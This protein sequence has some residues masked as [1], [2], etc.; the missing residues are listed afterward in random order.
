MSNTES[1]AQ[2]EGQRSLTSFVEKLHLILEET[3]DTSL[4]S[5][6][7]DGNAFEVFD[8]SKFSTTVLPKFFK[9]NNWQSFVR[10][11]NMYGFSKICDAFH[12]TASSWEFK[13]PSF[14]RHCPGLF[15]NIRRRA[16][17]S[18]SH[19][20]DTNSPPAEASNESQENQ[21]L[22]RLEALERRVTWQSNII[23]ELQDRL[24]ASDLAL[25]RQHSLTEKLLSLV[26]KNIH[27][28]SLNLN[29]KKQRLDEIQTCSISKAS[30]EN[31][32]SAP[33]E[34]TL[35]PDI[36]SNFVSS[37]PNQI[38]LPSITSLGLN[39]NL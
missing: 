22:A 7:Q 14:I 15:S 6:T 8:V 37:Y 24:T 27:E 33:S 20:T 3:C 21:T 12:G 35:T 16:P 17:R 23:A 13:H 18:K 25:K 11:L 28:D 29:R 19:I 36:S 39:F 26:S 2:T 30:P 4:V 32:S 34:S 5:W 9:H 1:Q 31:L 10:Q 38:R